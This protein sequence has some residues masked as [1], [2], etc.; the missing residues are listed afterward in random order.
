M[1][2]DPFMGS[3]STLIAAASN[4]RKSIG[5][6]VD[7]EYCATAKKR[8]IAEANL[9]EKKLYEMVADKSPAKIQDVV[10]KPAKKLLDVITH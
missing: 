1:V 2:L 3:G 5:I 10:L 8:I 9:F 4:N 7:E 6:E